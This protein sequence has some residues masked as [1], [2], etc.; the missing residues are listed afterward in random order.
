MCTT[1]L[2]TLMPVTFWDDT[3]IPLDGEVG[4]GCLA[5]KALMLNHIDPKN[6]VGQHLE[7]PYGYL[8]GMEHY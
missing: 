6:S 3:A 2:E 7:V 1:S 8:T 5:L 4:K